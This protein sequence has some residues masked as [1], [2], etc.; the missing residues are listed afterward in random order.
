M[1]RLKDFIHDTNDILLAV[2][3]VVI[4]AG[5]IFWRLNIILDYPEKAAREN[6]HVTEETTEE[7]GSA[8]E[9]EETGEAGGSGETEDSGGEETSGEEA[10]EDQEGQE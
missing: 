1:K 2:I 5:I 6:M 10:A 8:E 4:A 7:A 3:I 9:A